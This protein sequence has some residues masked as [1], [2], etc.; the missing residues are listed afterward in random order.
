MVK[1]NII[2]HALPTEIITFAGEWADR[3]NL[4]MTAIDFF[5]FRV[6]V[7]RTAI[8]LQGHVESAGMPRRI[9]L[10]T[11][12]PDAT[13]SSP[14]DFMNRNSSSLVLDIGKYADRTLVESVL[15]AKTE[16]KEELRIWR[17]LA[18]D[19]KSRTTAGLWGLN[20]TTGAKHYYRDHRYTSTV[21]RETG[22]GLQLVPVAGWNLLFIDEP[23]D[24]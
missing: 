16:R 5:P 11:R 20:P 17:L 22:H 21:A 15:S 13:A 24:G 2:F 6:H 10:S 14:L 9:C 1:V 4:Y 8:E 23:S 7:L 18:S 3:H 19:L 12:Q